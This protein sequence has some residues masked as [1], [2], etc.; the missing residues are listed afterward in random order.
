MDVL[1]FL[2]TINGYIRLNKMIHRDRPKYP[3]LDPYW[4]LGA[5]QVAIS[6]D[7]STVSAKNRH[8]GRKKEKRKRWL[9]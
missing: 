7:F 8:G 5:G 1:L 9:R 3:L 4:D 6:N 2:K